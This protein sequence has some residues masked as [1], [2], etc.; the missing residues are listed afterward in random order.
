VRR[1]RKALLSGSLKN[2]LEERPRT[3]QRRSNAT[4][5]LQTLFGTSRGSMGLFGLVEASV[6]RS[7]SVALPYLDCIFS[8]AA[9]FT[10][11]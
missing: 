7:K 8:C 4:S 1:R 6:L 9:V 3:L 2:G 10:S 11:P 5:L